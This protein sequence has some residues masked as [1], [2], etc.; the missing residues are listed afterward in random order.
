MAPSVI[1]RPPANRQAGIPKKGGSS[2]QRE[3]HRGTKPATNPGATT[4]KTAEPTIANT[5]LTMSSCKQVLG[6]SA[7]KSALP[8]AASA[9]R[10]RSRSRGRIT[11]S[12]KSARDIAGRPPRDASRASGSGSSAT[13]RRVVPT[14]TFIGLLDGRLFSPAMVRKGC[15]NQGGPSETRKRLADRFRGS[16]GR[17]C[18]AGQRGAKSG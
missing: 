4:R 3:I 9:S 1:S 8:I 11:T 5:R 15:Q 7:M 6:P 18:K 17:S 12:P 13:I 16:R 10:A 14:A 2:R